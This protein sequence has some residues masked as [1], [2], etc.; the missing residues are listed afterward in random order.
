MCD[1]KLLKCESLV[2][3]KECIVKVFIGFMFF[4]MNKIFA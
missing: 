2:I 1:C 3:F 4:Y